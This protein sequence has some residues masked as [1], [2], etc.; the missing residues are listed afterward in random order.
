MYSLITMTS[1]PS[2]ASNLHPSLRNCDLCCHCLYL[3]YSSWLHPERYWSWE[4]WPW[5]QPASVP[6]QAGHWRAALRVSLGRQCRHPLPYIPRTCEWL[7]SLRRPLIHSINIIIEFRYDTIFIILIL[8]LD[9]TDFSHLIFSHTKLSSFLH[10][11]LLPNCIVR[12]N[13]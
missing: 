11:F 8:I 6:R 5:C 1:I 2:T 3:P 13:M 10:S 9:D 12:E 4:R 7:V